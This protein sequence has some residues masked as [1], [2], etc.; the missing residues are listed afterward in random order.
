MRSANDPM[1]YVDPF[2]THEAAS[3]RQIA[4]VAVKRWENDMDTKRDVARAAAESLL[5]DLDEGTRNAK[6]A[7][8][9]GFI[10]EMMEFIP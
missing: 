3:G 4:L 1:G 6:L 7:E 8:L 10:H 9:C 2:C 5:K